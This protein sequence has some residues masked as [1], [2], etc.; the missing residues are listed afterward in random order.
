[1]LIKIFKICKRKLSLEN[2][3]N[4]FEKKKKNCN[5]K[6]FSSNRFGLCTLDSEYIFTYTAT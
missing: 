6:I 4:K 5:T 1:M 3:F 2:L